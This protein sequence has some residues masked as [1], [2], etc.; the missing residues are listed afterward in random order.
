MPMEQTITLQA[1]VHAGA[2][3]MGIWGFYKI[4]MEIIKAIT[5]RHDKEQAWDKAVKSIE[6][7][8]ESLSNE[9][10]SRL[11]E[12]DAKIQQLVAMICMTLKAQDAILEALVEKQIGNGEIK[13]MHKE[14]KDFI[15]KQVEQ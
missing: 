15:M 7:D 10:N 3:I 14:L 1:L 13:S 8:R 2:I 5:D 9:F 4:V 11:D 12:Q 6:V